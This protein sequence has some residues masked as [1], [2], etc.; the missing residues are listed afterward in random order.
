VQ[1]EVQSRSCG[2]IRKIP[3]RWI[4]SSHQ[5]QIA[6]NENAILANNLQLSLTASADNASK[7]QDSDRQTQIESSANIHKNQLDY[8]NRENQ[9]LKRVSAEKAVL[10]AEVRNTTNKNK[11]NLAET[12]AEISNIETQ[13]YPQKT[14]P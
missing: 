7:L 11:A 1:K 9:S 4:S 8:I 2:P 10:H 14:P 12:N 3:H 6:Y 13:Q 5:L